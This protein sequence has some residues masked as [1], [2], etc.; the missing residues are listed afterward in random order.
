MDMD[1]VIRNLAELEAW[2]EWEICSSNNSPI[3]LCSRKSRQK[4][5]IGRSC[6][7]TDSWAKVFDLQYQ[8]MLGSQEDTFVWRSSYDG[9]SISKEEM[10]EWLEAGLHGMREFVTA[11]FSVLEIGCG[12]G[13][14]YSKLIDQASHYVGVDTAPASLKALAEGGAYLGNADKTELFE[15]EARGVAGI[16]MDPRKLVILNS[17][18]QYFP[19]LEYL[20]EVIDELGAVVAEDSVIYLGDVRSL[21]LQKL[22]CFDVARSKFSGADVDSKAEKLERRERELLFDQRF[23]YLLPSVFDWIDSAHVRVKRGGLDN[24]MSR[25]RYEVILRCRTTKSSNVVDAKNLNWKKQVQTLDALE[26]LLNTVSPGCGVVVSDIP[27]ERLADVLSAIDCTRDSGEF[28]GP[29]LPGECPAVEELYDRIDRAPGLAIDL[30]NDPENSGMLRLVVCC[31]GER[32]DLAGDAAPLAEL[33][34]CVSIGEKRSL[35]QLLE[36][37]EIPEEWKDAS[38]QEVSPL[39]LRLLQ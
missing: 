9:K 6:E 1:L 28:D 4:S 38:V 39:L 26:N 13:L 31:K 12:N 8:R 27:N 10:D 19:S 35:G 34:S 16:R 23:F 20:L 33:S 15:A 36:G 14:I 37:E 25:Y 5:L 29:A 11:D 17:V 18:I 3:V 32:I 7:I 21:S 2:A 22:F 24:E 30:E